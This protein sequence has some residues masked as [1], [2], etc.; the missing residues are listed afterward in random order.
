MSKGVKELRRVNRVMCQIVYGVL[1]Y[2]SATDAPRFMYALCIRLSDKSLNK[3]LDVTRDMIE[4]MDWINKMRRLGYKILL[5]GMG[6][7]DLRQRSMCPGSYDLANKNPPCIWIAVVHPEWAHNNT[8][9]VMT[10]DKH[11]Y[12]VSGEFMTIRQC[13]QVNEDRT[14]S[15]LRIMFVCPIDKMWTVMK[16]GSY[17][18]WHTR[19]H[20][21]Q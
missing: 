5:I 3:Y 4:L 12:T 9:G 6:V 16:A 2:L 10:L 21:P 1:D 15:M 19:V 14:K 18:M 20:D 8:E 7:E 17:P 13:E 11:V